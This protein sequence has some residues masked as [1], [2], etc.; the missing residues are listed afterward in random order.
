MRLRAGLFGSALQPKRKQPQ[1]GFSRT[2]A[3][4]TRQSH[5]STKRCKVSTGTQNSSTIKYENFNH[6]AG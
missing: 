4:A 6:N 3:N 1:A 2:R 5:A